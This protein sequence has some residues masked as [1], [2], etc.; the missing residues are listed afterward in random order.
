MPTQMNPRV[1][2]P[3][4]FG[5]LALTAAAT[6]AAESALMNKDFEAAKAP[7]AA[8][9]ADKWLVYFGTYTAPGKSRGVYVASF[10]SATGK[11]GI[12]RLAAETESPSFLALH[13]TRPLLYAVN[14]L[15]NFGGQPAGSVSTFAIDAATGD[16]RELGRVSSRGAHPCHLVVDRAG[17]YVLVAN[18]TGG[19][20]A[21]FALRPDGSLQ[22]AAKSFVQHTGASVDPKRQKAP[23]AHMIA[24][25]PANR[26]ALVADLGL[27]QLLVYAFDSGRLTPTATPP[28]RIEPG[29]GP[30]HFAFSPNPPS[31]R[32]RAGADLYV[33]NEMRLTITAF[34][35]EASRLS[36]F[37]SVS[38]LPA[39]LKPGPA[40]SGAEIQVHP[41]GRFVYASLR[42]QDSLAVFARDAGTGRLALVEHV[43]SG[44][45]TPRSFVIDPSGR[46]LLAAN[47]QSDQVVL[48]RIDP[49][50]GR[51]Q[52]TGE[53]V[54]VGAP[55]SMSFFRAS[56][57]RRP[58]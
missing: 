20:V 22:A 3:A 45:R 5:L 41:S 7:A 27:D 54:G 32:L 50:T 52:P 42:G 38:A 15:D 26:H 43:P 8:K 12:P 53:V 56:G 14:E 18:Y 49:E 11:L 25:D 35:Y 1:L 31:G 44:G 13:P 6:T 36:E 30:R 23:H 28:V 19:S 2:R 29:S 4:L 58:E 34:R 46:Y 10:D 24:T 39:S 17:R 16:L 33:L 55:V 57:P 40:D 9:E 21:S 51:L 47:Q 48:Y 37:Q